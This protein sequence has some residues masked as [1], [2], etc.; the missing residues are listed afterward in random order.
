MKL[1]DELKD[2]GYHSSIISTFNVDIT[3]Y[4]QVV[5]HRLRSIG[6]TNNILLVD[7]NMWRQTVGLESIVPRFIG[8]SYILWPVDASSDG[9][10]PF[11]CFHP[12][13]FL[14]LGKRQG[15][16]IV[17]SANMTLKG[18][19]HNQ[20]ILAEIKWSQ[21]DEGAEALASRSII[22]KSYDYLSGFLDRRIP[23]VE[24]KLTQIEREAPWLMEA[25]ATDDVFDLANG[26]QSGFLVG[27]SPDGGIA[28]RFADWVGDEQVNRLMI[29]S[30]YWNEKMDAA[31]YLRER[32]DDAETHLLLQPKTASF[33]A[34]G[35]VLNEFQPR[36]LQVTDDATSRFLHAKIIVAE[37]T[38]FDHVLIGSANCTFAALGSAGHSGL[39]HEACLYR[40]LPAG[41]AKQ[42]LKLDVENFQP[43]DWSDLSGQ[44]DPE[45][46][47]EE[48]SSMPRLPGMVEIN[49][50][51]LMWW[52]ALG[53]NA[54][55]AQC[56]VL[57]DNNTVLYEFDAAQRT[58]KSRVL[59]IAADLDQPIERVKFRLPDGVETAVAYVHD[60]DY[61]RKIARGTGGSNLQNAID[62]LRTGENDAIAFLDI[63]HR[64]KTEDF[65][66]I[67][68]NKAMPANRNVANRNNE[69]EEAP[70]ES[71]N[72]NDN[73]YTLEEF[74]RGRDR[75]GLTATGKSGILSAH[76][77]TFTDLLDM[78]RHVSFGRDVSS[79]IE[80]GTPEVDDSIYNDEIGENNEDQ[81]PEDES[82]ASS[83]SGEP[84][85][86]P[87][88]P[89]GEKPEKSTVARAR[90]KLNQE[91][92]L[93]SKK[94][95]DLDLHAAVPYNL[96]LELWLHLIMLALG[97]RSTDNERLLGVNPKDQEGYY[98]RLVATLLNFFFAHPEPSVFR[99]IEIDP[100][101][102]IIP[103]DIYELIP[104]SA[105]SVCLSLAIDTKLGAQ[106]FEKYLNPVADK[107]YDEI[108]KA[109]TLINIADLRHQILEL[110]NH[111]QDLPVSPEE[112][113]K[114][115]DSLI[116][117]IK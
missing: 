15:R 63:L 2:G 21:R 86:P 4:D 75:A 45:D 26:E 68:L 30:P 70:Q 9:G 110:N 8:R 23:S 47:L 27:R 46:A 116:L 37:G 107:I 67:D 71:A 87:E 95:R 43:I 10:Q 31:H 25:V 41:W 80:V 14:Q 28:K 77:A 73:S 38:Q 106:S 92:Q 89:S 61:L 100:T 115:H 54:E 112:I 90:T 93:F 1:Y 49:G 79:V 78:L 17:G 53:I 64:L 33:P 96:S 7:D 82:K 34:S 102:D 97:I 83:N 98:P 99:R 35:D 44:I 81:E 88:K 117:K 65:S 6:C 51:F 108:N 52:P 55:N 85:T 40:R 109:S 56:L 32:F 113:M 111:Q 12:K 94:L 62:S 101:N 60:R 13:L 24:Q 103:D 39:N 74:L 29:V 105:W 59:F 104:I 18:Y 76:D 11:S 66:K 5:Q 22:R 57:D 69:G 72:G 19:A 36:E 20:E 114:I 50:E 84:E 48:I 16:L 58:D 3:F 91:V 42:H